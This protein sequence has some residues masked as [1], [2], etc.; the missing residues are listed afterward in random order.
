MK[1]IVCFFVIVL[2]GLMFS[3]CTRQQK[4]NNLPSDQNAIET[5]N[6]IRAVVLD[7]ETKAKTG[8]VYNQYLLGLI[9][10][11]GEAVPLDYDKAFFWLMKAAQSGHADAQRNLGYL[12]KDGQG[13]QKD[14]GQAFFGIEK[15]LSKVLQR[16]RLT[17]GIHIVM[18]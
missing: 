8:D 10:R 6:K 4:T 14:Y 11:T 1:K 3:A 13:V 17:L 5:Q 18:E 7:I 15:Q 12:F 16:L 2:L 9:Y